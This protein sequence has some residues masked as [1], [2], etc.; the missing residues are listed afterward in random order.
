MNDNKN[1]RK[2]ILLLFI[3][4]EYEDEEKNKNNAE[5]L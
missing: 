4:E 2:I 5:A 3:G 1:S